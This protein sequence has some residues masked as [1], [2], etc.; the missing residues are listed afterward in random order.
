MTSPFDTLK[1]RGIS[2]RTT[3]GT[4]FA[5]A[6]K[7]GPRVTAASLGRS[8]LAELRRASVALV[9]GL[10]ASLVAVV[11]MLAL[12]LA[13]GTPTP[14]ELVGE[15]ILP[16]LSAGQFVMLL[17]QFEPHPKTGPLFLA[18]LGQVVVGILLAPLY[19]RIARV[20]AVPMGRWPPRR[21]WLTAAA[22]VLAMELVAI[23]LFWPVLPEGLFGD[24]I[25][26]AR[27][28]T[29]LSLLLTFAAYALTVALAT[30]WLRIAWGTWAAWAVRNPETQGSSAALTTP[31]A[32][33]AALGAAGTTVLAV[34]AGAFTIDRLLADYLASSNLA[35]EGFPV[36][37]SVNVALTPNQSFYVV[38]KNAL[39]PVVNAGQWELEVTGLVRQPKVWDY[40]HVRALPSEARAITMECISNGVGGRLMSTAEWRGVP[41]KTLLD[42]AGGTLPTASH[43]LFTSVDGFHSSLPLAGLLHARTL[44]AYD[45]NGVPL[46]HRHGFP[47]RAVV[48]GR[49]GEQS[50]KW[51]TRI[52]ALDYNFKGFYQS[53]GWSGA[54]LET[55]SRIDQPRHAAPL[56]PVTIAGIAF[57]GIRGIAKVEVSTD[58]GATWYAATLAPPLSDQSWVFWRW[59]WRPTSPGTYTLV[60]R[61]TDGTGATQTATERGTVPDGATGWHRV[62]ITVR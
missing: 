24:P 52:E 62:N 35:Y 22:F 31:I 51:V 26:K 53:Q 17:I 40:S 23:L 7:A 25:D 10:L 30:H 37:S 20:P 42:E 60:V 3:L 46:P 9:A 38:S 12:R 11:V 15:R 32:R 8:L 14:P 5:E 16:Q 57:A 19:E 18:L 48:P 27:L 58:G 44:L 59:L 6:R 34:A 41:L 28:L 29:M 4:R 36:P 2:L 49:Y 21:A 45:M 55:T 39:D 54:Q 33:R 56:G 47:L 1:H 61:T 43:V 13:W 50:A